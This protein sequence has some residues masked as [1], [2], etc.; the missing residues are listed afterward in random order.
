[1]VWDV[2]DYNW[3][4][5]IDIVNYNRAVINPYYRE[6]DD[7]IQIQPM[8]PWIGWGQESTTLN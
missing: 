8:Q 4:M 6:F 5:G 1:M 2:D 7:N 3:G